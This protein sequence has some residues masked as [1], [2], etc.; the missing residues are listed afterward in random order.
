MS[1]V[2]LTPPRKDDALDPKTSHYLIEVFERL[3]EGPFLIQGYDKASLPAAADFGDTTAGQ[4]FTSLIFVSDDTGGAIVAFSDGT[5]W[6]RVT[7]RAI[8]S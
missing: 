8:I 7:D 2:N 1:R 4:S 6:R 5:N 3:G